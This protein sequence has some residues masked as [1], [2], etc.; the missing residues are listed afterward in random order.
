V[1]DVRLYAVVV[2]PPE[3]IRQLFTSIGA[4]QDDSVSWNPHDAVRI[5]LCN[6]GNVTQQDLELLASRLRTAITD[7]SPP[8]ICFASGAALEREGD[9]TVNV[10]VAGDLEALRT[11]ALTMCDA[12]R[13]EGFLVDR[14]WYEPK[15]QIARINAGTTAESL[16][17]V[18][19]RLEAYRGAAWT[20]SEVPFIEPRIGSGPGASRAYDILDAVHL[21]PTKSR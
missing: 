18:V 13:R 12:G 19:D 20:V 17:G 10:H 4:N 14:R 21:T 2:P 1:S 8:T 9:D 6:F 16:Q 5:G 15:A 11:L 3:E 7:L